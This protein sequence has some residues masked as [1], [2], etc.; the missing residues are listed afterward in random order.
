MDVIPTQPEEGN[1][2]PPTSNL[3]TLLADL[4][5]LFLTRPLS[6]RIPRHA[7][8]RPL[9]Q[10]E[11]GLGGHVKD[12]GDNRITLKLAFYAT[13]ASAIPPDGYDQLQAHIRRKITKLEA[14]LQAA[15]NFGSSG[16]SAAVLVRGADLVV[17]ASSSSKNTETGRKAMIHEI[18]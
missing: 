14:E 4:R 2:P 15:A 7:N 16:S 5:T 11:V 12:G 10:G 6:D 17:G 18:N 9:T 3:L 8:E 1:T 13:K